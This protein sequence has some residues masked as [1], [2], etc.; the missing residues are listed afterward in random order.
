VNDAQRHQAM[1]ALL[2][3]AAMQTTKDRHFGLLQLFEAREKKFNLQPS[4]LEQDLLADL[5][6]EHDAAVDAFKTRIAALQE[7]APDT[8][9]ALLAHIARIE[10][11]L[12]LLDSTRDE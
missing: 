10:Q 6:G 5:L 1:P 8:L 7:S 4:Q 3:H 12:A 2:A 11:T 9:Q